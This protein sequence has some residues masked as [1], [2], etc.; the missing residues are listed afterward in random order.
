MLTLKTKKVTDIAIEVFPLIVKDGD[1]KKRGDELDIK[2]GITILLLNKQ[3]LA[4]PAQFGIGKPAALRGRKR[5]E[6]L[7]KEVTDMTACRGVAY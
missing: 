1:K 7:L 2:P 6:K 5:K 3:K 4:F